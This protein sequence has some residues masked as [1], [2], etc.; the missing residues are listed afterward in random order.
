MD[1][2]TAKTTAAERPTLSRRQT[3]LI[4]AS[5]MLTLALAALDST[6]VGTALPTIVAD[7]SGVSLYSWLIA[8][9]LLTS[10]TTVPLYGRLADMVG[11]KPVLM[12]GIILFLTGSV[13]CGLAQSMVQLILFRAVQGLGA[14]AI[15]PI[16]FTIVGDLFPVE[17]RAR[18]QGFFGGVWGTASIIGPSLGGLII[19][20]ASWHW[21]FYINVP[22]GLAAM[23]MLARN[24][25]E[26]IVRR[27]HA[28]DFLGA[29]L[30]TAGISTL[31]LALENSGGPALYLA[32]VGLLGGFIFVETRTPEPIVPLGL[33]GKPLIW[34]G[35]L[36]STLSGAV[37]FGTTGFIPL[38]VQGAQG[39]SPLSVGAVLAPMSI[40]WPIGSVASGRLIL[41][42]GYRPVLL[43]G[44][45][46]TVLGTAALQLLQPATPVPLVMLNVALVGLGMGL[47]ST[48]VL[49]SIQNA[50]G[51]QQRGVATALNQFSRT[52]GGSLGVALM[53]AALNLQAQTRLAG[54]ASGP[55]NDPAT[56]VRNLLDPAARALYAGQLGVLQQALA[57][58]LRV[59]FIL[60]L[61][62]AGFA[63]V[64]GVLAFPAGGVR[65]HMARRPAAGD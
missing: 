48:P 2:D 12:F 13:L 1:P 21:V 33:L 54:Q 47:T 22:L 45:S 39:G 31:L 20:V 35:Y 17:Q 11:R 5:L 7:L 59:V 34:V 27:R 28:V 56:V 42:L 4:V 58:A 38:F 55:G 50:V 16:I 51:W 36:V 65:D 19:A 60:P 44:L 9:Y 37:Q 64:L 63:L 43:A 10:T 49:I 25:H 14:G 6:I 8:A 46:A 18:L 24:Y 29:T 52:I 26:R 53:G 41:R 15:Q 30:L 40:G 23:L 61:A 57:E 62:F 32:A 3:A